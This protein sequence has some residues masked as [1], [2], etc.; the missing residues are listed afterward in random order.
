MELKSK[1]KVESC[2]IYLVYG[3]PVSFVSCQAFGGVVWLVR[4]F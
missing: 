3:T 4:F 1:K 2:F